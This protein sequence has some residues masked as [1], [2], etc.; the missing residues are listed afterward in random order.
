MLRDVI[1][2]TAASA[3]LGPAK[4]ERHLLPGTSA[5][6]GDVMIRRWSDGK[7][8]A[9][10][11][12]VTSPLAK[13][14]VAGAAAKAGA[15]L[16]KACLRKKRETEDACRQ[17]GLVFLPFALETLGGFHSGALAQVKLLGSALARSKG[18][19]EN[20]VTS[21]FFGRL[22]SGLSSRAKHGGPVF[23]AVSGY[24][25]DLTTVPVSCNHLGPPNLMTFAP[26]LVFY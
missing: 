21:Q 9:I 12:T 16:D 26:A 20:E 15:S 1:F 18:L 25:K 22:Q 19:D 5:R 23:S 14:N 24:I 4:E 8:A 11:V 3:D 6:P 10:D 17:E 7:D 13:S 2:E